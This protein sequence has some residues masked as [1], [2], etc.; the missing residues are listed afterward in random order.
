MKVYLKVVGVF[1][2]SRTHQAPDPSGARYT[3]KLIIFKLLMGE[4]G[5]I[6]LPTRQGNYQNLFYLNHNNKYAK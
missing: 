5:G 4:G 3:C 2:V 6:Q 1:K